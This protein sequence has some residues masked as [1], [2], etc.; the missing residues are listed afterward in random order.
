MIALEK[1]AT[2]WDGFYRGIRRALPRYSD[3][4]PLDLPERVWTGLTCSNQATPPMRARWALRC[5][6]RSFRAPALRTTDEDGN[7]AGDTDR[8]DSCSRRL[9]AA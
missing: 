1:A 5:L 3:T 6:L 2:T 4:I 9:K 7:Q 8:G